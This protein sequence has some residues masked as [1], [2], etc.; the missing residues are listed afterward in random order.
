MLAAAY[1]ANPEGQ[2]QDQETYDALKEA[3]R[4]LPVSVHAHDTALEAVAVSPPSYGP[5]VATA[6]GSSPARLWD[7]SGKLLHVFTDQ[8]DVSAVAF[9]PHQAA[10]LTASVNKLILRPLAGMTMAAAPAPITLKGLDAGG[11]TTVRF[12][13]DEK[14][15][16]AA[17]DAGLIV[18]PASGV[19]KTCGFR[20]AVQDAV[21]SPDG[22]SVVAAAHGG[23]LTILDVVHCTGL[24]HAL[25]SSQIALIAGAPDAPW[26]AAADGSTIYAYDTA[27][28]QLKK[29][30]DAG[31]TVEEISL[32]RRGDQ[33]VAVLKGGE[34]VVLAEGVK[35][36]TIGNGPAAFAIFSPVNDSIAV[37][38]P[39]GSVE[40]ANTSGGAASGERSPREKPRVTA[41]SPDGATL[42]V[43]DAAGNL[44]LWQAAP[45]ARASLPSGVAPVAAISLD[46]TGRY[47]VTRSGSLGENRVQ[48]W[49][50][51]DGVPSAAGAPLAVTS[52]R[53]TRVV[54]ARLDAD[55]QRLVTAAGSSVKIW[56]LDANGK[57]K[58]APVTIAAVKSGEY[59]S[60]AAFA[61]FFSKPVILGAE[62]APYGSKAGDFGDQWWAAW[63][64]DGTE[65]L[66][67]ESDQNDIQSLAV[68]RDDAAVVAFSNE[69]VTYTRIVGATTDTWFAPSGSAQLTGAAAGN[70]RL[71]AT[72]D[73]RGTVAVYSYPYNRV[74]FEASAGTSRINALRFSD[75]NRWLASAGADGDVYVWG[76]QTGQRLARLSAGSSL[77]DVAFSPRG[78]DFVLTLTEDGRAQL[79][80]R[81]SQREIATLP[82]PGVKVSTAVF[83]ADGSSIVLG[84]RDGRIYVRTLQVADLPKKQDAARLVLDSTGIRTKRPTE[85]SALICQAAARV[86]SDANEAPNPFQ[87]CLGG[88]VGR[89]LQALNAQGAPASAAAN[90]LP[91]Y[92]FGGTSGAGD[93]SLNVPVGSLVARFAGMTSTLRGSTGDL[94]SMYFADGGTKLIAGGD[95]NRAVVWDARTGA[96]VMSERFGAVAA[97][98]AERD[99]PLA[100][101]RQYGDTKLQAW[102]LATRSRPYTLEIP[103]RI[104]GLA[105]ISP[106]DK[107]VLTV[108]HD[109]SSVRYF[110]NLWETATGKPLP[111][112]ADYEL[113]D[114]PNSLADNGRFAGISYYGKAE[115][116]EHATGKRVALKFAPLG[117]LNAEIGNVD[118]VRLRPSDDTIVTLRGKRLIEVWDKA[119]PERPVRSLAYDGNIA[120]IALAERGDYVAISGDDGVELW[121]FR[122]GKTRFRDSDEGRADLAQFSRD[123]RLLFEVRT[124][125]GVTIRSVDDWHVLGR[126]ETDVDVVAIPPGAGELATSVGGGDVNLWR[127]ADVKPLSVAFEA[128]GKDDA[129]QIALDDIRLSPDGSRVLAVTADSGRA[130]MWTVSNPSRPPWQQRIGTPVSNGPLATFL[131]APAR[132]S[133]VSKSL[134]GAGW[135]VATFDARE[136]K[137]CSSVQVGENWTRSPSGR[138]LAWT[139]GK[140]IVVLDLQ[141]GT[142]NELSIAGAPDRVVFGTSD[143][144]LICGTAKDSKF[145]SRDGRELFST[146]GD[147]RQL[148]GA[149]SHDRRRL[150]A[151]GG[152]S[153]TATLWDVSTP[154]RPSVI[155]TLLPPGSAVDFAI[156]SKGDDLIVARNRYGGISLWSGSGEART[157]L[158]AP[159]TRVE[160]I[161]FSDDDAHLIAQTDRGAE[162][163][164]RYGRA[165]V[166]FPANDVQHL[167]AAQNEIAVSHGRSLQVYTLRDPSSEDAQNL[168]ARLAITMK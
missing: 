140:A 167:A 115:L 49:S 102:N 7:R 6:T 154:G 119:R 57:P 114:S 54:A 142:T 42:A 103:G 112:H 25:A 124:K 131:S 41:F 61:T 118:R 74:A 50:L 48:V 35:A 161:R 97:V 129:L 27:T 59:F 145:V 82:A 5:F 28:Q 67:E 128:P 20:G 160:T 162:V 127:V 46:E 139:K 86:M 1:G 55:G 132:L 76:V 94:D 13:N 137:T 64:L 116:I 32:D 89:G 15:V 146:S 3:L 68:S 91:E 122:T 9:A 21:F 150:L 163:W 120:S 18:T 69:S 29:L 144:L 66:R 158:G 125:K 109:A 37:V 100:Y 83:S 92:L 84:D 106:D 53:G 90:L 24:H 12:S 71:Y 135:R 30:G 113:A 52:E 153:E 133:V 107:I 10:L 95:D 101:V 105:T 151:F 2:P 58:A 111:A 121:N 14:N 77:K 148:K 99:G 63:N 85:L 164:D 45:A 166:T 152:A 80:G 98:I 156:F 75:D 93:T 96:E 157:F 17:G 141:S 147:A 51:K 34:T 108:S 4:R 26:V 88:S 126:V 8:S 39:N 33:A 40:F 43:G 70:G 11:V 56:S 138:Y 168:R 31:G 117:S 110:L 79:W 165:L 149:L 72:G 87:D 44:V 19:G 143:D 123:G 104:W 159:D 62:R 73:A 78:S 60:D 23:G 65:V 38:G 81:E 155:T 130:L 36:R 134:C 16:L 136:A 22:T 47:A